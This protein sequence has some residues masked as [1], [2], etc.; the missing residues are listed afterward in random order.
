[1]LA[2]RYHANGLRGTERMAIGLGGMADLTQVSTADPATYLG[3]IGAGGV[4]P[5]LRQGAHATL[6]LPQGV[7]PPDGA[8]LVPGSTEGRGHDRVGYVVGVAWTFGKR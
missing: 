4:L 2:V 5:E 3:A 1:M 8:R 7:P 6:M